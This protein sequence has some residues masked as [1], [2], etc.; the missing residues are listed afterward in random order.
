LATHGWKGRELLRGTTIGQVIE[1]RL[2]HSPDEEFFHCGTTTDRWRSLRELEDRA[3]RLAGGLASLGVTSGDRVAALLPNCVETVELLL[4]TIKLGAI[5]VPLNYW[6]KDDLL[7]FQLADSGARVL[8]A[9]SLGVKAAANAL[10]DT[11]VKHVVQVGDSAVWSS[12]CIPYGDLFRSKRIE[13]WGNDDPSRVVSIMYTSGTTGNPK[14]CMLSSGY[15][16]SAGRSYGARGWV[17]PGDR[18]YTPFQLFHASGQLVAFMSALVNEAAVAVAPEFHASTFMADAAALRA[19]TLI[20]VGTTATAILAQPPTTA[21]GSHSFRLSCWVPL[22]ENTQREFRRRFSVP[23]MAEGFG[24]TECVPISASHVDGPRRSTTSGQVAPLVEV[25]IADGDGVILEDGELGEILVRPRE[26]GAMFSGYWNQP[27]ASSD[28]GW[29]RTGDLGQLDSEGFLTF[30]DRKKDVI[31]RRGENVSSAYLER[32]LSE[33][34]G[35][36]QVAICGVPAELGDDDIKAYV[37]ETHSGGVRAV[38]LFE[39]LR[40]RIPYFAMP[41]YLQIV[42]SL[43]TN[44]M[45]RVLKHRLRAE[46]LAGKYS[47][48]EQLGLVVPPSERRGRRR[49]STVP[50]A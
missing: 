6:L 4:A 33:M 45:G 38:D 3:Q 26:P 46:G 11:G 31:R 44:A 22:A 1:P 13:R 12:G 28:G 27:G 30:V 15:Y 14:G 42:D 5:A 49:M 40:D 23:V 25:R 16:V 7:R 32:I 29:H 17:V 39:F 8:V 19:T 24:Q 43:P 41:R 47:D 21:D 20:G 34:P 35:I 37:V 18:I 36:A 48:F 10:A 2:H 50:R 9:D